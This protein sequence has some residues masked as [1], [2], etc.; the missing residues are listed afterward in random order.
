MTTPTEATAGAGP[1]P[2]DILAR[3]HTL[4]DQWDTDRPDFERQAR[5]WC[6]QGN[7]LLEGIATG[8]VR[9]LA[10]CAADLRN[11]ANDLAEETT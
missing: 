7:E 1:S 11:L 8:R 5:A 10:D 2:A 3:L 9:Q 4:A 6:E